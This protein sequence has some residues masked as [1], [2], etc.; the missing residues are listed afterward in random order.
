MKA[1][2]DTNIIIDALQD[3]QPWAEAAKELFREAARNHYTGCL[4]AKTGA[5]IHYLTRR[6]THS[7]KAA[8]D[9]MGKL[10]ALFDL[11]DTSAEDCRRALVSDTADYE[12]AVIQQAAARSGCDYIVTRNLR[13]YE[14]S[15]VPAVSPAEFVKLALRYAR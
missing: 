12:D 7:E 11:L 5:D 9:V 13:D 14:F 2:L 3:R 6:C 15:S 1:L 10:F 4:T 8:R